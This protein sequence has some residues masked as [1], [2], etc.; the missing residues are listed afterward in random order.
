[1]TPPETETPQSATPE[2]QGLEGELL[3]AIAEASDLATLEE[4]RVA[5]LGKKG[6]VS[7]LMQRLGQL[8][9]EA[10]KDFGQAVNALKDRVAEALRGEARGARRRRA[11]D[12]ARRGARRRHAAGA[13]GAACR[14]AHPPREPGHRRDHRDLRRYGLLDRRRPGHRDRLQQFHRAQHSARAS[15]AAGPRHLL[16]R[17][18]AGRHAGRCSAPI[19]ARCRSAPCWSGSRRS[20]SSRPAASIAATPTRPT[21]RCSI[22]SKGSPSTR[23]PISAI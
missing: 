15:G 6:R 3:G 8:P 17:G 5:A 16:F 1:M 19:R 22:R 20:A 18:R 10:R 4:V 23:R 14:G 2:L 7:E 9:P 11:E 12:A 13:R 21:R